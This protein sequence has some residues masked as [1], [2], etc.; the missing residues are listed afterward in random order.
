MTKVAVLECKRG[1]IA[2]KRCVLYESDFTDLSQN[3][4]NHCVSTHYLHTL[5]TQEFRTKDFVVR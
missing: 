1:S 3:Q 5:K 4:H 2:T